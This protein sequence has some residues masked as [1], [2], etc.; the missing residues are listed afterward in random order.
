MSGIILNSRQIYHSDE[1]SDYDSDEYEYY[2]PMHGSPGLELRDREPMPYQQEELQAHSHME[3][4]SAEPDPEFG[5]NNTKSTPDIDLRKDTGLLYSALVM[6]GVAILLP[7]HA[8]ERASDYYLQRFPDYNII[9]DIHM[10][11]LACNLIGV[12]F[13][14][15]FIETIAF[16]VR[17]MGG[18][19]AALSSL[20]FLTIFD[21]LLELFDENKG[22]EVTMAAVGI[23]A[24]G[25]SIA[26]TSAYGYTAM[27]PKRYSQGVMVG[28]SIAGVGVAITRVISKAVTVTNFELGAAIFFGGCMGVLLMAVFLFHVSRE[29]PLVKH[30]ISKCQA[31]VAVQHEQYIKDEEKSH[32]LEKDG[33]SK[34]ARR[35][36][37]TTPTDP[38]D[39]SIDELDVTEAVLNRVKAIRD[40]LPYAAGIGATY[41]ITTSL[42]PSVFIM[43]KSEILG[44]WMPLILICIFNA[45]DLFGKIL[46]SLGNIWSGVQLM[47]WA[48]SRFLFVAV[49]LL[50]VMPL[51][52]PMLSHEAYSCCFAALLG[53]TN[54]YLASIFMIEAGLHMEDGRREVAGNIMTLALC[55]GLSVGI[56]LAYL[57]KWLIDM[58][59]YN[60]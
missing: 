18:I 41:C 14:N 32:V 23:S 21:M 54:G 13:G 49:V 57:W 35:G 45:F 53:I 7:F 39:K 55:C 6:I 22:Y 28:E 16:H 1:S 50:C 42:Y 20:M 10:V 51:M 11:Y 24:L 17:V 25:I 47:L 9:F 34:S 36:Y 44:S 19:G 60:D 3:A 26:Q 30:C 58:T 31:A 59:V 12:L 48:V 37:G 5:P 29:V 8:F 33:P 27:L 2:G 52:H 46:S 40:L 43:V 15:L 38:T 4:H 56:G